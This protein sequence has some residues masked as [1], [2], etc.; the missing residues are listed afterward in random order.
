MISLR[1][2]ATNAVRQTLGFRK[3]YDKKSPAN[4]NGNAQ[5][6]RCI[7][8]RPVKQSIGLSQSPEA[9]RRAATIVSSVLLVLT[10]ER[11]VLAQLTPNQ[12]DFFL[13]P[14]I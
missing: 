4:A 8:E 11:D 14:L 12:L 10:R 5:Q 2:L 13:P 1:W 7:F 9:A 3:K 6:P